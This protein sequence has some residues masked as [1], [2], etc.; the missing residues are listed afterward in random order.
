MG[1][2]QGPFRRARLLARRAQ[3]RLKRSC[4][5]PTGE[6][7][8]GMIECILAM[9]VLLM[10]L[11]PTGYLFTNVL[12]Q[13]AFARERLTALSIAEQYIE[14]LDNQGPPTDSNNQPEV[15]VNENEG[16]TQRSGIPYDVHAEFNWTDASG[17]TPDFCSSGTSPVLGLQ[18]TVTWSQNQSITDQAILNFPASGNLTDGYLAVQ[19]NGDPPG[20]PPQDVFYG[21][22]WTTRVQD[23]PVQ[24]SGSSL[25]NPYT[26]NPSSDGCTFIALAPGTY[27]VQVGPG[28]GPYDVANNNESLSE[29]QPLSSQA[30]ISVIDAE[31]TQV[32]FQYDDGALVGLSYPTTTATDDGL[33]CPNVS[34]LS[35]IAA[36]QAPSGTA[37][38]SAPMAQALVKTSSGWS[39]A[40]LPSQLTRIESVGC[41][42]T[43]CIA[44]GYGSVA[45]AA[46][47]SVNG[48]AW[49]STNPLPAG[50]SQLTQ[51]VC[52]K[53]ASAPACL[54]TG[55]TSTGGVVLLSATVSGSSPTWTTDT[56]PSMTAL[57][58]LICP[59]SSAQP[60][61]F[62][63]AMTSA[64]RATI[65]SNTGSSAPGTTWTAATQSGITLTSL[66]EMTCNTTTHCVAVGSST[67]APVIA[68][69]SSVS[70]KTVTWKAY[71]TSGFTPGSYT[72]VSCAATGSNCWA[73]GTTSGASPLIA[74]WS[75][76]TTWKADTL[77]AVSSLGSLTCSGSGAS[78]GCFAP[79]TT[80][81]T[82]GVVD[83]T[84]TSQT[85][86]SAPT[87]PASPALVSVGS[88]YC[89]SSTACYATGTTSTGAALLVF[90]SGTWS[91]A[92]FTSTPG[93]SPV[94]ING[95]ACTSATTCE[96]SGA[97]ETNGLVL[98][99]TTGTA[100]SGSGTPGNLSGLYV[101]DPPIMVSNPN[102]QPTTVIEMAAPTS[103]NGPQWEVGP[104]FPFASG[105][106]VAAGDC[107]SELTTASASAST[108]PG[109]IPTP[110]PSYPGAPSPSNPAGS[111]VTVPM[112][113]L[114]VQALTT[115]GTP[116]LGA[117]ITITDVTCAT[118][119]TPLS[120]G[121][122]PPG[123]PANPTNPASYTM[124]NSGG[125]GLSRRAVVYGTYNVTVTVG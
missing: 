32:T 37:P 6:A 78:F 89:Y 31:I 60:V 35:C 111:T 4:P 69:V 106:S 14:N 99:T 20:S 64:T 12:S 82:P 17:G 51:I 39:A 122:F 41:T 75:S 123:G 59:S 105:Y 76:G 70:G 58:Q 108:S 85:T 56:I 48:T 29:T 73:T 100:F 91:Y 18:V 24:V 67:S 23:V 44:V 114:P 21:T 50:V 27:N 101:N 9:V 94:V 47:W 52:P 124:P 53:S 61:C 42:T 115:S 40:S 62:A 104:L 2:L 13:S 55:S 119:L 46:A 103:A 45:G 116:I 10:V 120:S 43:E 112:G 8:F 117:N 93:G 109:A 96:A 121:S 72:S 5:A 97:T 77:P 63:T 65:I 118:P 80:T 19:V 107:P 90:H 110:P 22:S 79:D 92:S 49:A 26:L 33:S 15:G 54:A 66:A 25:A 30:P 68:Y 7:G 84:S 81:T 34:F 87:L 88:I 86:W 57:G 71:G 125:D 36:G 113:L 38:N 1:E 74:Y 3:S 83:I 102:L 28:P 98:D 16:T 95:I 11:V